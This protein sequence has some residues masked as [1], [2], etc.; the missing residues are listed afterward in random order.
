MQEAIYFVPFVDA[1]SSVAL[2]YLLHPF[3][4]PFAQ[5]LGLLTTDQEFFPSFLF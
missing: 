4:D 2:D 5:A 1:F 3:H